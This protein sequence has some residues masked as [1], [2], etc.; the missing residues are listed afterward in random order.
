MTEPARSALTPGRPLFR[1]ANVAAVDEDARSLEFVASDETRDRYGDVIN[2]AGW[3][4]DA[5]RKNP[6]FL[7]QH[8]Y[9]APIGT[10]ERVRVD[11]ARLL[12]RVKFA[13][14]GIS[15]R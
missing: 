12:A 9:G 10:V 6:I 3:Q 13:P 15:Q 2:A 4:L 14:A 5:F 7:W 1:S 11:G 8:D